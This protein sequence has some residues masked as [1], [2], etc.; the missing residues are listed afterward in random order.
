MLQHKVALTA[1]RDEFNAVLH[2]GK[3]FQQW[4]VDSY[5]QL[6]AQQRKLKAEQ[7]RGLASIGNYTEDQWGTEFY[8]GAT[9]EV[10]ATTTGEACKHAHPADY[11]VQLMLHKFRV[12]ENAIVYSLAEVEVRQGG[13]LEAPEPDRL[14]NN[15]DE[16]AFTFKGR[17]YYLVR[18]EEYSFA[19]E[20]CS[21]RLSIAIVTRDHIIAMVCEEL[22]APYCLLLRRTN[23]SLSRLTGYI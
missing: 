7:Y 16:V 5:V 23:K 4:A 11:N 1:I 2:A 20:M 6:E 22:D 3:L 9:E 21:I 15:P 10:T 18:N 17:H 8:I 12:N 13:S 19:Y 14:G